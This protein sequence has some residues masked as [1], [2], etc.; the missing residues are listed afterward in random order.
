[1]T[2]TAH[3][4]PESATP[5]VAHGERAARGRRR[6]DPAR[7]RAAAAGEDEERRRRY[8]S[9]ETASRLASNT[10]SVDVAEVLAVGLQRQRAV[11]AD[12]DPVE[13]VA[14]DDVVRLE[15]A[16]AAHDVAAASR[17]TSRRPHARRRDEVEPVLEPRVRRDVQRDRARVRVRIAVRDEDERG[18]ADAFDLEL[19]VPAAAPLDAA[20][21]RPC[22]T[23]ARSPGRAPAASRPSASSRRTASPS[24]PSPAE[25]Q[26]RRPLTAPSEIRRGRPSASA[27][28]TARA[29]ST[30]SRGSPSARGRT[31][32]PP[33]GRNPNG[34]RA[35]GAVQ[36]LV[37]GAVAGE[38]DDRVD[39]ARR[40]G[41]RARSRGR[42]AA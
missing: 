26:K 35:V 13:V 32:V 21:A 8:T 7:R 10:A 16:L 14:R 24:K 15:L 12:D 36:R 31:L 22:R 5:C 28:P 33:P 39:V 18:A 20:S 3:L 27:A 42:G 1:M 4:R 19:R 38:D 41:A 30:G 2:C 29:A 25:K 34:T 37:V 11:A 17:G 40:R 9:T 6:T 23:N